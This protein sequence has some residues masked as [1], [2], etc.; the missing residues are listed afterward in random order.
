MGDS[1]LASSIQSPDYD[2]HI[3]SESDDCNDLQWAILRLGQYTERSFLT[4]ELQ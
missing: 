2:G 1:Y 4:H 3:C